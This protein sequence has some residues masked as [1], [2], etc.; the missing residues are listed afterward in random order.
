MRAFL[1][2]CLIER[3]VVCLIMMSGLVSIGML[4]SR[5]SSAQP[6]G[7]FEFGRCDINPGV[8]C[9]TCVNLMNPPAIGCN[10]PPPPFWST[11]MCVTWPAGTCSR[12]QN[13]DCGVQ[14]NCG[15]GDPPQGNPR[16][17]IVMLC[18]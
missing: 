11:G 1:R 6:E 4:Y 10:A 17:A 3:T 12:W 7:P 14:I 5:Q 8:G 15:S 2:K 13:Y 16:C 18:K 9:V